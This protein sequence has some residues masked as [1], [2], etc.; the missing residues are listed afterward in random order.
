MKIGKLNISQKNLVV[1][2]VAILGVI[3]GVI[4]LTKGFLN[5][6]AKVKIVKSEASKMSFLLKNQKGGK[7]IH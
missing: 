3:G 1:I 2:G 5:P 6:D 4:L 7:L